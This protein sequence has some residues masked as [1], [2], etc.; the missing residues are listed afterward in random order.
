MSPPRLADLVGLPEGR[1]TV[2]LGEPDASRGL[3]GESWWTWSGSG[4]R[5]RVRCAA[6]ADDRS[7]GTDEAVPGGRS[8]ASWSL[9]WSEG[10]PTLRAALEPLGLWPEAAPDVEAGA[11]DRP[12]A[13]RGIRPSEDGPELSLTAGVW[14]G[15]FV[16]VACFDEAPDWR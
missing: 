5:L 14:D 10:R 1:L 3:A 16:R 8:V 2:R 9:V 7:G 11:L 12:L 13:R 4:W 15:R 6:P